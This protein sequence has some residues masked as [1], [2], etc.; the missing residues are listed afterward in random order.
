MTPPAVGWWWNQVR[1]ILITVWHLNTNRSIRDQ[2]F[3]FLWEHEALLRKQRNLLRFEIR[4]LESID[5]SISDDGA[6]W[7]SQSESCEEGNEP[8]FNQWH[9]PH[10]RKTNWRYGSSRVPETWKTSWCGTAARVSLGRCFRVSCWKSHERIRC[11]S[12]ERPY[13]WNNA[14]AN[15][16][17]CFS[18]A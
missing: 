10:R 9:R 5:Q 4:T 2:Y 16:L 1:S 13:A 12:N 7:A 14:K 11:G 18:S 3:H 17:I 15:R 8:T 6:R